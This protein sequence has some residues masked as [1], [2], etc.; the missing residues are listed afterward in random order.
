MINKTGVPVSLRFFQ[1]NKNL[2]GNNNLLC[3][4]KIDYI[5]YKMLEE[6]QQAERDHIAA[7]QNVKKIRNQL[8][9]VCSTVENCDDSK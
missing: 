2:L 7:L 8:F 3:I 6:W 5:N 9:S 4:K 1:K